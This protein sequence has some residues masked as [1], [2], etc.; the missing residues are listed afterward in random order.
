MCGLYNF[1]H[2]SDIPSILKLE[3]PYGVGYGTATGNNEFNLAMSLR[4]LPLAFLRLDM[5]YAQVAK[6]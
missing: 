4:S 5:L 1:F 6:Q 2:D 3:D